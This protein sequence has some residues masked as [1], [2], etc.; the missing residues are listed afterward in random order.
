MNNKLIKYPN[1]IRKKKRKKN[2]FTTKQNESREKLRRY[3]QI[4]PRFK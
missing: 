3:K 1:L 2:F 4:N